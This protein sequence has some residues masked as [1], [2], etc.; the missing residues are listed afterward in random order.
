MNRSKYFNSK[1]DYRRYN[2]SDS[3]SNNF[4]ET[5]ESFENK[6]EKNIS[7][8]NSEKIETMFNDVQNSYKNLSNNIN[9]TSNLYNKN[10]NFNSNIEKISNSKE[11]N[12]VNMIWDEE[13]KKF[14][15]NTNNKSTSITNETEDYKSTYN[16]NQNSNIINKNSTIESA[17]DNSSESSNISNTIA[18]T[19]DI[20]VAVNI[21][22]KGSHL[23][24]ENYEEKI[25]KAVDTSVKNSFNKVINELSNGFNF[26]GALV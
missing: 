2:F 13:K 10:N 11:D 6:I 1:D 9:N 22:F 4:L 23:T 20:K 7:N 21:D 25:K 18:F 14:I 12:Y 16:T 17:Y 26:G 24:L 5:K 15:S 8:T 19:K 3:N